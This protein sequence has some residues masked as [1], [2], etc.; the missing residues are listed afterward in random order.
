MF[1]TIED[2][3]DMFIEP[4]L[5]LIQI[6]D[7]EKDKTLYKGTFSEIPDNYLE[8]SIESIDSVVCNTIIINI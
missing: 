1:I 4:E 8:K 2:F 5:Q 3:R 6:Y 7:F